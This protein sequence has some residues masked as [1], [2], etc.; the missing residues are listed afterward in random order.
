MQSR[1]YAA[2]VAARMKLLALVI[3]VAAL[4]GAVYQAIGARRSARRFPPPGAFVGV[5]GQRLHLICQGSGTPPVVFES[6]LAASS[7]SWTRVIRDV[8]AFTRACAY[9]RAG[10]GWSDRPSRARSVD[11][12]LDDLRGVLRAVGEPPYVLVGHS[13]GSFLIWA[14]AARHPAE[15]AGL[16]LLDPPSEWHDLT[17]KSARMLR[18]GIRLARVGAVLARF[19]VVRVSLAF[20]T[21]GAPGVPRHA[22]RVLG[23]TAVSTL[24]K[25]V[26]EVRKLPSDVHPIVEALWCQPKCFRAMGDN[27]TVLAALADVVARETAS[28]DA[29]VVVVSRG[30]QPPD[31]IAR[32]RELSRRTPRGRHTIATGSG[33]WIQFDDPELIVETIRGIV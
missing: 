25:L 7:V 15:I 14:Y 10:F 26:R 33:H 21:G 13:F 32:H 2:V 16:V 31:A 18:R 28:V 6:G 24:E 30:D 5:A 12:L 3:V 23:P 20:L 29:P 1:S 19:G 22:L 27:L 17:P 9:D 8:S 4:A 11:R